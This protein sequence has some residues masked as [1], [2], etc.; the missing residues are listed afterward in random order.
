MIKKC[1]AL[2]LSLFALV[3]S[4]GS[5][6]I[7]AANGDEK[8]EEVKRVGV[9]T[10]SIFTRRRFLGD[11][12]RVW[13]FNGLEDVST[14]LT[15]SDFHM[16]D[17]PINRS[18]SRFSSLC[19]QRGPR[20]L[21]EEIFRFLTYND[22]EIQT[23]TVI[24]LSRLKEM[25]LAKG[26]LERSKLDSVIPDENTDQKSSGIA[27]NGLS[28]DDFDRII[29]LLVSEKHR[30]SKE[31]ALKLIKCFRASKRE[32]PEQKEYKYRY[33]NG[34]RD[35]W[36]R[37]HKEYYSSCFTIPA[38]G[39]KSDRISDVLFSYLAGLDLRTGEEVGSQK[40]ISLEEFYKKYCLW[41]SSLSLS[42]LKYGV[43]T[44][45]KFSADGFKLSKQDAA[46]L[47]NKFWCENSG[48]SA[49]RDRSAQYYKSYVELKYKYP[50]DSYYT[51]FCSMFEEKY[52]ARLEG[53][54]RPKGVVPQSE[55]HLISWDEFMEKYVNNSEL[56]IK[57]GEDGANFFEYMKLLEAMMRNGDRLSHEDS[58]NFAYKNLKYGAITYEELRIYDESLSSE[59]IVEKIIEW[60]KKW[61]L[62]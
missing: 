9:P 41:S 14:S 8:V 56:S 35:T 49:I 4:V 15:P 52:V 5:F 10:D 13:T 24:S 32:I 59:H 61:G 20:G 40:T 51:K 54:D 33:E 46:K 30:L 7:C 55:L 36:G 3:S 19:S 58:R 25:L 12:T 37:Y 2:S 57:P 38:I 26:M 1:L 42:D 27:D 18:S 39:E 31:D 6:G 60:R 34:V 21:L 23:R 48:M 53:I 43:N 47:L 28:K 17:E 22:P 62:C 50:G 45:F 16:G 44:F 11:P 29:S